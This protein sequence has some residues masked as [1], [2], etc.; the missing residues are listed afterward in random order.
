MLCVHTVYL[1]VFTFY[2]NLDDSM[3]LLI[4][5]NENGLFPIYSRLSPP[6][7]VWAN[8]SWNIDNF[9]KLNGKRVISSHVFCRTF[10]S[11]LDWNDRRRRDTYIRHC[12]PSCVFLQLS[13]VSKIQKSC[14]REL[15][16]MA[17]D[18]FL[19]L[20]TSSWFVV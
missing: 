16:T 15:E 14:I 8:K 4:W 7:Q 2:Y 18:F 3:F 17:P 11:K 12:Y 13:T 10:R 5:L 1:Q 19:S 9:Q 6:L 20:P